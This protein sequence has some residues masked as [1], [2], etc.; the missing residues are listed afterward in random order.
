[1]VEGPKVDREIYEEEVEKCFMDR[2]FTPIRSLT[3]IRGN[4]R[5]RCR[6]GFQ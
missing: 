5:E 1:M 4:R 3:K 2:E 6:T